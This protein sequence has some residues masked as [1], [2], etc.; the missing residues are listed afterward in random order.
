MIQF[1]S[2]LIRF[3]EIMHTSSI[4]FVIV[5]GKLAGFEFHIE[6]ILT[7][8]GEKGGVDGFALELG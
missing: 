8:Q 2:L 4:A 7:G 3:Y 6:M 1:V 5:K